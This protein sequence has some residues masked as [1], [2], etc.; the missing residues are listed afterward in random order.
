MAGKA[1]E[2]TMAVDNVTEVGI[3]TDT[4]VAGMDIDQLGLPEPSPTCWL[5]P[6]ATANI[7]ST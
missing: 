1:V 7:K 5:P 6:A 4:S 3:T 2:A